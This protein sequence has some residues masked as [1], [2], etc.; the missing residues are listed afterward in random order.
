MAQW[1]F[2]LDLSDVWAAEMDFEVKR[3][4]IVDR[5]L[6]SDFYYSDDDELVPMVSKLATSNDYTFDAY[7][8][9][10]YDFADDNNIWVQT[11]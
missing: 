11:G 3:D 7:F 5:I 10:F 6:D 9:A 8:N 1:L 4:T 2:T